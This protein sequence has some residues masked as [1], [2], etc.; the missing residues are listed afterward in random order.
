MEQECRFGAPH[1]ACG[2]AALEIAARIIHKK[3]VV[4]ANSRN[5]NTLHRK[6]G[7]FSFTLPDMSVF[8]NKPLSDRK[9]AY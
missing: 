7:D 6:K 1:S 9:V 2:L 4:S 3:H 8:F 5:L